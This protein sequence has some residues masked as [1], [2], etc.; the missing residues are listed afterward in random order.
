M[1]VVSPGPETAGA[2]V[3]VRDHA[4]VRT[5]TP[6]DRKARRNKAYRPGSS[7]SHSRRRSRAPSGP[8]MNVR[9]VEAGPSGAWIGAE[10]TGTV[11]GSR[12]KP[13]DVV[14]G[15]FGFVPWVSMCVM[16]PAVIDPM[17]PSI[18]HSY[19]DIVP[20]CAPTATGLTHVRSASLEDVNIAVGRVSWCRAGV[21][22][23]VSPGRPS[24]GRSALPP[25][26]RCPRPGWKPG[27]FGHLCSGLARPSVDFCINQR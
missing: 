14:R 22:G 23:R 5:A 21:G 24:Y 10:P 8:S 25:A 26:A 12:D 7:D 11:V 16:F 6:G 15:P 27:G 4:R 2:P 17:S 20:A 18:H 13:A 9:H 1:P 3:V 19:S